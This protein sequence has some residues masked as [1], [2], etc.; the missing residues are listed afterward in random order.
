MLTRVT[1]QTMVG[2]ALRNLQG[3]MAALAKL[4]DKSMTLQKISRP[5]D[6]PIGAANSMRVRGEQRLH[7]Q[8]ARNITDGLGWLTTVD[9]A[10]ISTTAL[11]HQARDLTVQGA[12]DGSLSPTAREAVAVKLVS[13]KDELLNQANTK[14][15]GRTVFAG[16]T[17]VGAAFG[18]DPVTGVAYSF[19]GNSSTVERRVGAETTVRVDANGADVFGDG[20]GSVFALIDT[21]VAD[22]RSGV[23]IG[24]RLT[25]LD[26]RMNAILGQQ[27]A[28]GA[29]NAQLFRAEEMNM[30]QSGALEAQR[31]EIEDADLGKLIL[32]LK[33]QEVTHQAALAVTART[34]QP[35]LMD[36]LR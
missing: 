34:L 4:Q 19:T 17:D 14:F 22:L 32:E 36:F 29:R 31:S 15:Q 20:P 1:G 7:E 16:N 27:G 13:L 10:L 11:L 2:S 18:N 30:E 23:N 28:V 3:S 12:N 35:T 33:L 5:S 6:D 26:D 24:P 8:Y 21:I 25:E 9:S